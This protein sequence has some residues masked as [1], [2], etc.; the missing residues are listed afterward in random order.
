MNAADQS[1]ARRILLSAGLSCGRTLPM[2]AITLPPDGLA[3][4]L[5]LL[6]P[7]LLALAITGWV[8]A[9]LGKAL[10]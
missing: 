1:L 7:A 8:G 3:H 9:R 2:L 4:P 10:R 6:A 5:S